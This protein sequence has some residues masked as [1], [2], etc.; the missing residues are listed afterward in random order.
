M[1]FAVGICSTGAKGFTKLSL[2]QFVAEIY[3]ND[4]N[5]LSI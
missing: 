4:V 5:S 3:E 2:S 1:P